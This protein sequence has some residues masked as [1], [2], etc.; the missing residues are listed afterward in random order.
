[1]SLGLLVSAFAR[2][3]FQAVQFMP[4]IVTP[5]LLLCG[6]FA[7]RDQMAPVLEALSY[8]L[9][10]TYAYEA[11]NRVATSG[12]LGDEGALDVAV[13]VGAT[14]LALVLAAATLRRRTP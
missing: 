11:L 10:L 4:A 9:P 7:P 1:M 6:L 14:V 5:Q 2:T 12:S 8:A 3:E 13:V